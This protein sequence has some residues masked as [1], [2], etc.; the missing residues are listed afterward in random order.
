MEN[1]K[2]ISTEKQKSSRKEGGILNRI[3]RHAK[4]KAASVMKGVRVLALIATGALAGSSFTG[5]KSPEKD[6]RTPISGEGV[7]GGKKAN[8]D[9][10]I[11]KSALEMSDIP[12]F[13]AP[14]TPEWD[15]PQYEFSE[16]LATGKVE[17]QTVMIFDIND[18]T[19]WKT[20]YVNA[21]TLKGCFGP[22][23]TPKSL[24]GLNGY[25]MKF[26]MGDNNTKFNFSEPGT[27]LKRGTLTFQGGIDL[28]VTDAAEIPPGIDANYT[29]EIMEGDPP[30][31]FLY[32]AAGSIFKL[33]LDTGEPFPVS[34]DGDC[35]VPDISASGLTVYPHLANGDTECRLYAKPT[36]DSPDTEVQPLVALTVGP[37]NISPNLDESDT[38]SDNDVTAAI[39]Y[40]GESGGRFIPRYSEI[41]APVVNPETNPEQEPDTVEPPIDDIDAGS[42]DPDADDATDGGTEEV[43]AGSTDTQPDTQP[44]NTDSQT[45][46][47]AEDT[48]QPDGGTDTQPDSEDGGADQTN[49]DEVSNDTAEE[50]DGVTN[51]DTSLDSSEVTEIS[52]NIVVIDGNCTLKV[53][54]T[55]LGNLLGEKV[56]ITGTQSCEMELYIG[57]AE[58]PANLTINNDGNG[59]LSL[60]CNVFTEVGKISCEAGL[61]TKGHLIK[62]GHDIELG[63]YGAVTGCSGSNWEMTPKGTTEEGEDMLEVRSLNDPDADPEVWLK[64]RNGTIAPIPSNGVA[65]TFSASGDNTDFPDMPSSDVNE[66][67]TSGGDTD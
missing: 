7:P 16:H 43:D 35:G 24:G 44:D 42:T 29:N 19:G 4:G 18:G 12:N 61:N 11:K 28:T 9:L 13:T 52:E 3:G 57:D 14:M 55:S 20:Y 17:G 56:D 49:P 51:P 41:P 64:F 33:N 23:V 62:H 2:R 60:T 21:P 67:D 45:P 30:A 47:D 59:N 10:K 32:V 46:P 63:A 26:S 65:Y 39:A 66:P 40:M 8:P 1:N 15:Q 27:F 31:P 36:L 58:Y 53:N 34:L 25:A 5:C 50:V 37:Q 22:G 48:A 54:P 38:A 6:P